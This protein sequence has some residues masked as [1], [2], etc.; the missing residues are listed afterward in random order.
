MSK[1]DHPH[2]FV[3]WRAA[4]RL[5]PPV[6]RSHRDVVKHYDDLFFLDLSK[7]ERVDVVE[8]LHTL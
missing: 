5:V 2:I 6:R 3:R 1:A 4:I 7:E 8:Y